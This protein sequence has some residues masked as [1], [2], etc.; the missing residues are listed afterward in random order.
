MLRKNLAER[1]EECSFR[2]EE[3]YRGT[4][5]EPK[6]TPSYYLTGAELDEDLGSREVPAEK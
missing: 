6:N 3:M 5:S 1:M 2:N 4:K